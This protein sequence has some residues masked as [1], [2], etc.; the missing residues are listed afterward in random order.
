M[1]ATSSVE[2]WVLLVYQ[3]AR[4]RWLSML[5]GCMAW[6]VAYQVT[7]TAGKRAGTGLCGQR[8][9]RSGSAG[10]PGAEDLPGVFYRDLDGH[11]LAAYR[12][13][14]WAADAAASG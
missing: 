3:G 7:A 9:G 6:R 8:R 1:P 10:L 11:H 12:S 5:A 13:M 4:A 14:T 2:G